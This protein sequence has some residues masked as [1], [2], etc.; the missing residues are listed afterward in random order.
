LKP[1][2]PNLQWPTSLPVQ[3]ELKVHRQQVPEDPAS[4]NSY[5]R[6]RDLG[7]DHI[8]QLARQRR[9]GARSTVPQ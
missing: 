1:T 2:N 7:E 6:L 8:A 5:G 9:P 3:V 4:H